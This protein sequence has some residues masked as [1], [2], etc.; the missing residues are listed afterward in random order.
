[1]NVDE[2]T[3]LQS[4][5]QIEHI[6]VLENRSFD[7]MLGYLKRDGLPEVNGLEGDETVATSR[8]RIYPT[9]DAG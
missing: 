8:P 9:P 6:V 4:L 1:M 3:A 7:H 5:G 2:S